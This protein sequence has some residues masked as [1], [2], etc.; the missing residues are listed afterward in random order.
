M[1]IKPETPMRNP[2]LLP[3]ALLGLLWL[4]ACTPAEEPKDPESDL[5]A[6]EAEIAQREAELELQEREMELARREAELAARE[7]APT[8]PAAPA[9][10]PA[11]ATPAPRPAPAPVPAS[12]PAPVQAA[13]PAAK[14]IAPLPPLVVPAGTRVSVELLSAISS[15]E[16]RRGDRVEARVVSDVMVNGER[17]IPTG[18][19]VSGTVTERTSGSKRIGAT[20]SITVSF[21]TLA[22]DADR[23]V[24][25][26]ARFTETGK[27]EGG[28]DA[29][30]IAGGAVA[31]A[32]IGKQV[33]DDKGAVVGGLLGAAA[34]AAAAKNT[35]TE[36]EV[37][38][39][40]VITLVLDDAVEVKR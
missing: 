13:A 25:M 5:A 7:Q 2:R 4:S 37:P 23:A 31:G 38:A 12:R 17:A 1:L 14:P 6:R 19:M 10:K 39:G 33:E 24:A 22:P 28:R 40:R 15:K 26:S 21:D 9:A 27:S 8:K 36:A 11:A 34:G 35:G 18:A 20:P 29:A 16:N 32:V 30:K 3:C